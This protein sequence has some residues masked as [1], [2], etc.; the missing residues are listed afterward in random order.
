MT[1]LSMASSEDDKLREYC[2]IFGVYGHPEAANLTYLGLYALQHRG[3]EAAGIV[4]TDGSAFFEHRR[5]GMVADAFNRQALERIRAPMAIG[6]VRYS[7]AGGNTLANVQPVWIRYKGGNLSVAHNGNLVNALTMRLELEARG[8]IFQS[9]MDTEVILHL[10]AC[11]LRKTLVDR[12]IDALNQVRG[13]YSLLFMSEDQIIAVRDPSG[14]R[15]LVLGRLGDTPVIASETCA[16]DLIDATYEREVEPGEMLVIDKQGMTSIRPF[17]VTTP[18]PCI[19]EYVYFARPDSR[20]YGQGVYELRRRMGVELARECPIEG[21][22]LVCPVPDSGVAA[23]LGYA[24]E[25]GL[26]LQM[27]LVRN[28]YVGRTFIEPQQS[29][30]NFGVKIKLNP[31]RDVL[32]GRRVVVID[33]SIVRGTTSQKIIR[34]VRDAGAQE[35][36]MRISAPPTTGPCY[37]GINTPTEEELIAHGREVDEIRQFIGADSLSYLS[38]E[39]LYRAVRSTP[40]KFCDACFSG[41]YPIEVDDRALGV[42]AGTS[43]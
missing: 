20:V 9:T 40:G 6:H 15:P 13:A 2:G 34:M 37:Y 4:S 19:F 22:D 25:S 12:V 3:Q 38:I 28:H 23:A 41:N 24:Q 39:G 11:S 16:L 10:V 18:S 14:F 33:D 21:A 42:K 7:T 17:P 36:H 43:G 30:R 35:V 8:S 32:E 26:P 1:P 27:G 5:M 31:I 29:I